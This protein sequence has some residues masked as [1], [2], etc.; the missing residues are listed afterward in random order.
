MSKLLRKAF[1]KASQLPEREQDELGR[2]L[3]EAL[4]ADD[5]RWSTIYAKSPDKLRR[6]ADQALEAF[7]AGRTE[8][9]DPDKL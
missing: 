4:E 3:L 9:L 7:R 6:L 2:W 1:E 8:E 5:R